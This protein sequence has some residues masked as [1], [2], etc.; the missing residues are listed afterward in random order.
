MFKWTTGL[1][2]ILR[3]TLGVKTDL[4]D[5]FRRTLGAENWTYECSAVELLGLR[6]W[7]NNMFKRTL[8]VKNWTY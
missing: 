4:A 7:L 5:M 6:T 2:N 3:G 1:I 8:G